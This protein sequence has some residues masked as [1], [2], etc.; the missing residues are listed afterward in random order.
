M[1]NKLIDKS[2][3]NM[4]DNDVNVTIDKIKM[5]KLTLYQQLE[6]I[7]H[8]QKGK[9][10]QIKCTEICEVPQHSRQSFSEP[11]QPHVWF[12]R[13]YGFRLRLHQ[14][15]ENILPDSRRHRQS[16]L[17]RVCG[18]QNKIEFVYSGLHQ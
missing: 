3:L 4:F 1:K 17:D 15:R 2:Q 6:D 18:D 5:P 9:L 12:Y 8:Y 14:P 11:A 16:R 7:Q 10:Y 13:K